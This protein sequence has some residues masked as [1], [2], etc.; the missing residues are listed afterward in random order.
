VTLTIGIRSLG[1]CELRID[2][3]KYDGLALLEIIERGPSVVAEVSGI[4]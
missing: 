3:P 1:T 2:K 4:L